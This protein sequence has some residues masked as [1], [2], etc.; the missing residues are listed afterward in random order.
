[1]VHFLIDCKEL[2]EDRD[3]NLIKNSSESSGDRMVE[4]L[5]KTEN[6][7]EVGHM[8][9]K[10][11]QR[12]R[13]LLMYMKEMEERKKKAKK[14]KPPNPVVYQKSDPGPVRRGHDC[15]EGRSLKGTRIRG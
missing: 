2:E 11:W 9:R 14:S 5:F 12:R 8:I 6:F 10:M 1:M 4:L 3:Y 15:P 13:K 7:Q